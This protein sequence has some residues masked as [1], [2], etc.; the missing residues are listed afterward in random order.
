MSQPMIVWCAIVGAL[1]FAFLLR[2]AGKYYSERHHK[3]N[4]HHSH[5]IEIGKER[6]MFY[7]PGD[8]EDDNSDDE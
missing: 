1:L 6:E 3:A 4:Y 8:A 5:V 2:T 7:V